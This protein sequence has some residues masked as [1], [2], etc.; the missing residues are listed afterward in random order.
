MNFAEVPSGHTFRPNF[1]H[2]LTN[3]PIIAIWKIKICRPS[4]TSCRKILI[5][6]KVDYHFEVN[7]NTFMLMTTTTKSAYA[8]MQVNY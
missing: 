7:M 6:I 4:L 5:S 2:W 3:C 8:C 1:G